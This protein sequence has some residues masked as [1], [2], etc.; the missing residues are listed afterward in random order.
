MGR[1]RGWA[2]PPP[3]YRLQCRGLGGCLGRWHFFNLEKRPFLGPCDGVCEHHAGDGEPAHQLPLPESEAPP[4]E[5][6]RSWGCRDAHWVGGL[7][8]AWSTERASLAPGVSSSGVRRFGG[9]RRGLKQELAGADPG[10]ATVF[11]RRRHVCLQSGPFLSFM[12]KHI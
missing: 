1:T 11:I 6:G 10:R 5:G 12:K 4:A 7:T 8:V 2:G 9:R 3:P